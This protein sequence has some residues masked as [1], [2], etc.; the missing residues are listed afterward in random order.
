LKLKLQHKGI[1][2]FR[3]KKGK[4]NGFMGRNEGIEGRSTIPKEIT[5]FGQREIE[6]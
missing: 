5:I 1:V 6:K 2:F 3:P 4:N